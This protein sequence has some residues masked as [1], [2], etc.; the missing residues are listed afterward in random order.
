MIPHPTD[1]AGAPDALG[2]PQ[3]LRRPDA[4]VSLYCLPFLGESADF[5]HPLCRALPQWIEARPV[6]LPG[7]GTRREEPAI[8]DGHLLAHHLADIISTDD[9]R[10]PF[11]LFGHCSGG[12]IAFETAR[13]LNQRRQYRPLLLAVSALCPPPLIAGLI[14][15]LSPRQVARLCTEL[16]G[17]RALRQASSH[18]IIAGDFLIPLRYHYRNDTPLPC[19]ISTFTGQND[20]IMH[21][22]SM[23]SWN[24]LTSHRVRNRIYPGGH[25]Y[26]T[27]HWTDVARN[28]THDLSTTLRQSPAPGPSPPPPP[29]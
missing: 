9:P 1:G 28:L 22:D 27:H 3:C 10:R 21:A 2:L 23:T 26:I 5:Y 20:P 17:H 13:L 4:A 24:S 6:E 19:P 8:R 18:A 11:A 15:K 29:S 12:L 14:R 25:F 7:H 16:A